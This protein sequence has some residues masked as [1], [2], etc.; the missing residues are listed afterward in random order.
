MTEYVAT[1]ATDEWVGI[2]GRVAF[3]TPPGPPPDPSEVLTWAPPDTTGYTTIQIP[4]SGYTSTLD[5]NTDYVLEM[6]DQPVTDAVFIKGGRNVVMIGGEIEINTIN[7]DGNGGANESDQHAIYIIRHPSAGIH[8]TPRIVHIEGVHMHG[9]G[10][11]DGIRTALNDGGPMDVD[12]RVQNCRIELGMWYRD[13]SLD[14]TGTP[15]PD[16][17]QPFGGL[18]SLR[19]DKLTGLVTGQGLMLKSDGTSNPGFMQLKRVNL[20]ENTDPDIEYNDAG[21]TYPNPGRDP[22]YFWWTDG[23]EGGVRL[24]EG[25]VWFNHPTRTFAGGNIFWPDTG[26]SGSDGTGTYEE[27]T[28]SLGWDGTGVGKVYEGDPPDGDYCPAGTPGTAYASPGYA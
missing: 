26:T 7:Y 19:V 24:D 1:P 17:L 25:T 11:S 15:H 12:L 23:S 27:P 5:H 2:G 16:I 10:L 6:P 21:A 18:D 20:K 28:N 9:Y 3:A 8:G 13:S 22:R 14:G 4:T